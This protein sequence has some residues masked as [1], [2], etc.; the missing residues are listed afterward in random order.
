MAVEL[1]IRF[2]FYLVRYCANPGSAVE[3]WTDTEFLEGNMVVMSH[4]FEAQLSRNLSDA[5]ANVVSNKLY[6]APGHLNA[7]F[8]DFVAHFR[9][10][11]PVASTL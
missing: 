7:Y 2:H 6:V 5:E 3:I 10:T 1:A 8:F 4:L 9:K 11:E